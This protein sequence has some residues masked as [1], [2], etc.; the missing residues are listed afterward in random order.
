[1]KKILI[2]IVATFLSLIMLTFVAAF[3]LISFV[4]LNNYRDEITAKLSEKLGQ[5]VKI[6]GV[7]DAQLSFSPSVMVTDIEIGDAKKPVIKIQNFYAK[8]NLWSLF[9]RPVIEELTLHDAVVRLEKKDGKSNLSF[10]NGEKKSDDGGG[11][12]LTDLPIIR[13]ADIKNVQITSTDHDA[14]TSFE[15]PI[16]II[17]IQ[18]H[19]NHA[20]IDVNVGNMKSNGKSLGGLLLEAHANPTSVIVESIKQGKSITGSLE[21]Y[22]DSKITT[23]IKIHGF[24]MEVIDILTDR[25][26]GLSGKVDGNIKLHAT[27]KGKRNLMKSLEG[28]VNL[29]S[30]KITIQRGVSSIVNLVNFS[31][32]TS[33]CVVLK[34][35][36]SGGIAK[37]KGASA[38]NIGDVKTSGQI[39]FGTERLNV[40]NKVDIALPVLTASGDVKITGR[41]DNPK[42]D[43]GSFDN[44]TV[45]LENIAKKPEEIAKGVGNFLDSA[46]N[47]LTGQGKSKA[48]KKATN[49]KACNELLNS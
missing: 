45:D 18:G 20:D 34:A 26:Y 10:G 16:Q 17:S 33:G 25:K 5:E 13:T 1:M 31:A 36:I 46:L 21:Y 35:P 22:P 3:L 23:D 27:G 11:N 2:Y 9:S 40:T 4:D 32:E 8:V 38:L 7:F 43:A 39:N 48:D 14:K 44:L 47:S 6:Y 49:L 15:I 12:F 41:F 24:S 37:L 19:A 42:V 30:D 28:E 29:Q